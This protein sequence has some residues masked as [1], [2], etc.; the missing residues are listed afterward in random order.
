MAGCACHMLATLPV[1]LLFLWAVRHGTLLELRFV[2]RVLAADLLDLHFERGGLLF[3]VSGF[4]LPL[5]SLLFEGL[6][7]PLGGLLELLEL[8][9]LFLQLLDP[10]IL[11]GGL[12]VWL[13]VNTADPREAIRFSISS[14][15]A[16]IAWFDTGCVWAAGRPGPIGLV[17]PVGT[18]GLPAVA[19]LFGTAEVTALAA[20]AC[21]TT[22]WLGGRAACCICPT[23]WALAV[24]PLVSGI[25][26]NF[27][28]PYPNC[29]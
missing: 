10:R 19:G 12:I 27:V 24:E 6:Y 22:C 4:G 8:L 11:Q 20:V 29:S 5:V 26:M 7:L 15:F 3:C 16:I 14:I 21:P 18:G 9:E 23:T 17:F 13:I 1:G 25:L 2:L 28:R